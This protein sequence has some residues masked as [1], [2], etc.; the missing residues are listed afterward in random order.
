MLMFV[1]V[2]LIPLL[3][4]YLFTLNDDVQMSMDGNWNWSKEYASLQ[5]ICHWD[6]CA[7][8]L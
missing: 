2:S 8:L 7:L 4:C 6:Q 3:F 5:S 1:G